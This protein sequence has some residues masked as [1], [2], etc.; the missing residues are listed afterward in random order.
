MQFIATV[1]LQTI[2]LQIHRL[3]N[4]VGFDWLVRNSGHESARDAW[5]ILS[6]SLHA[7]LGY[8][9][10]LWNIPTVEMERMA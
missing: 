3:I 7:I 9:L 2:L 6:R 10:L 5:E 4:N 8:Y 1:P